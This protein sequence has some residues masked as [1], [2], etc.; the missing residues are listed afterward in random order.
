[1]KKLVHISLKWAFLFSLGL[2]LS[3]CST[4]KNTPVR[5]TYHNLTSYYNILFNGKESYKEGIERYKEA[6]QFDFTRTLPIFMYGN[7]KLSE[8]IKSQMER[9]IE[10]CSKLIKLHSISAKPEKLEKK[11]KLT[12]EEKEYYN[13]SEFNKFVDDSYLL[14]GKAYFWQMDYQTAAKILE[15]AINEF[16]NE[17]IDTKAQ[18]WLA[19]SYIELKDFREA[20]KVLARTSKRDD[21]SAEL[22]GELNA[23]YADL[24]MKQEDNPQAIPYI[25]QA[26]NFVEEKDRKVRYHFIYAQ[27]LE[28]TNQPEKAFAE[29]QEVIDMRPDYRMEF[30]AR[31]KRAWLYKLTGKGGQTIKEELQKMLKDDKNNDYRDQ[32]YYALGK[33]AMQEGKR[34]QAI[35]HYKQSARYSKKNIN[36]KGLS[37]L[38][39]AD[40]YFENKAYER[41]QAYYDSSVTSLE[42]DYPG[43]TDLYIKTRNLTNLVENLNTIQHQ[44]SLLRVAQLSKTEREALINRLIQRHRERE[45]KKL[46]EERIKQR[47]QAMRF[48]NN[49]MDNNRNRSGSNWY[50]YSQTAKERGKAA[51]ERKWGNRKLQDNWRRSNQQSEQFADIDSDNATA[52]VTREQYSKTDR[53]YY[54]QEIPLTDS[55]QKVSH[56]KIKEAY[57]N[58]GMA[59]MNDLK[60]K[61]KAI[62]AFETLNEKYPEHSFLLPSYYYLYKMN[63]ESGHASKASYYKQKITR[64]FPESNYAKVVSDPNYFQKLEKQQNKTEAFYDKTLK[65]YEQSQYQQVIRSCDEALKKFQAPEYLARFEYLKALSI[66]RTQDIVSFRKA[67]KKVT[68]DYPDSEVASAAKNTLEFLEKTELEQLSH[69]FAQNRQQMENQNPGNNGEEAQTTR[70]TGQKANDPVE[71]STLYQYN[72]ED[73]YYFVV[74]ANTENTDIGRLKFDLIN[75]NLDYYLQKDYNTTSQVFNKFNTV[76]TVKRFK[77]LDSVKEYY[78]ILQKKEERVF[79]EIDSS[80]YKYF[81]ISVKNYITLLEKKSIIEYIKFFK[82]KHL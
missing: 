46:E 54:T 42:T 5:R 24:Y 45:R 28:N 81:Y 13:K 51:F 38:A 75:F 74:I 6:Y 48:Q 76:I 11:R 29:Y 40:I 62:E 41:A 1:M 25:Q 3:F 64:E 52:E 16:K 34:D 8:N 58:V 61:P 77:N 63:K 67:L 23:T 35:E 30:N 36:Q 21:M 55:A 44:D 12:K 66:G 22:I 72:E 57:F 59:Y 17:T 53:K 71:E 80:E 47:N 70:Q 10:K 33:I 79:S 60:N 7:Q 43:Y 69:Y 37:F 50:F 32:I 65:L 78:D 14:M 15:Y 2:I 19:R 27:L 9:T 20:E 39:L 73:Q 68:A 49:P 18:I 31:L 56:Q 26:I 82:N 4:N